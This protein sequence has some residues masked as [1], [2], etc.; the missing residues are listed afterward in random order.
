MIMAIWKV[1]ELMEDLVPWGTIG[2]WNSRWM[3]QNIVLF[4]PIND[5]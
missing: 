1:S 5:S 3:G 2:G 4:L